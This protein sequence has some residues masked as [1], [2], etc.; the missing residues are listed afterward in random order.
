MFIVART[1]PR[2]FF[3]CLIFVHCNDCNPICII[4]SW[5]LGPVCLRKTI[6]KQGNVTFGTPIKTCYTVPVI[7]QVLFWTLVVD[8]FAQFF[9]T[10]YFCSSCKVGF[11]VIHIVLIFPISVYLLSIDF[12]VLALITYSGNMFHVWMVLSVNKF[13]LIFLFALC[14]Y[15]FL[16]WSCVI[17]SLFILNIGGKDVSYIPDV[18]LKTS[19]MSPRF[20][21]NANVGNFNFR[22]LSS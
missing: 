9:I 6:E 12:A 21:R 1:F 16:L 17:V 20:L 22:N 13:F 18:N 11:I 2:L 5:M 14:R 19:I 15:I 7:L 8:H 10:L 3:Y 4:Y